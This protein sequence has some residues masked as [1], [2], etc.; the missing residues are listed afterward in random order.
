LARSK[1]SLRRFGGCRGLADDGALDA[2]GQ[3]SR[4][5][6]DV[7]EAE[8]TVAEEQ[9]LALLSSKVKRLERGDHD[10]TSARSFYDF[11]RVEPRS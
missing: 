2:V 8:P 1:R 9:P 11:V 6:L 10:P 3:Y 5:A 4:A 7:R